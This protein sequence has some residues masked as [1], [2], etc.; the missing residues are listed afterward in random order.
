VAPSSLVDIEEAVVL[1]SGL[2]VADAGV[3]AA[4]AALTA[5]L[6]ATLLEQAEPATAPRVTVLQL[7]VSPPENAF[8]IMVPF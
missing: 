4:N 7:A 8:P 6:L 3:G 5:R 1:L 2:E